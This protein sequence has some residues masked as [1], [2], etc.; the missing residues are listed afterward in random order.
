MPALVSILEAASPLLERF[1]GWI[2]K[3]ATSFANWIEGHRKSGKLQEFFDKVGVVFSKLSTTGKLVFQ[4]IGDILGILFNPSKDASDSVLDGV[5]GTLEKVHKWLGD[6]KNQKKVKDFFTSLKEFVQGLFTKENLQKVKDF[7]LDLRDFAKWVQEKG[8]PAIKKLKSTWETLIGPFVAVKEG[9]RLTSLVIS[10]ALGALRTTFY[11]KTNEIKANWKTFWDT[12]LGAKARTKAAEI[13]TQVGTWWGDLKNR[14]KTDSLAAGSTWNTWWTGLRG[15]ASSWQNT[16]RT[17]VGSWW[18][19]VRGAF[20]AG[21]NGGKSSW[22]GFWKSLRDRANSWKTAILNIVGSLKT[23]MIDRFKSLPND[24]L[25]TLRSVRDKIN[26]GI[27]KIN[28]ILPKQLDIPSIPKFADG[29]H[30]RG[31]GGEREDRIPALLSDNEYVLPAK[32]VRQIGVGNLDA[33]RAGRIGLGGDPGQARV[34]YADGGLVQRTQTFIRSTDPKPY[35][36][37]AVGPRGYDCSGLTGEVYN[38]LLGKASYQ[39]RFTTRSNFES[40]GFKRG[41]GA[42]TVGVNAAGGHMAGNLAGLPFEAASTKSGIKVGASAKSV[43][44]FPQQ[45]YLP[46]VGG[47]FVGSGSDFSAIGAIVGS[48]ASQI[49]S[50][51]AGLSSDGLA[52]LPK[53]VAQ[54]A[55][56]KV[57]QRIDQA[58]GFFGNAAGAVQSFVGGAVSKAQAVAWV[59]AAMAATGK[60]HP[61]WLTG[62]LTLTKRESNWNPNAINNWDSNARKGTPSKGIAQMIQ[63]TFDA[64][65]INGLGGIFNPIANIAASIRYIE[66]R[67]GDISRVQQANPNMPPKGYDNGGL[68]MPGYTLAYNGTGRAETIRT[69]SQEAALRTSTG[70]TVHIHLGAGAVQI[71]CDELDDMADVYRAI[72]KAPAASRRYASRT[73]AGVR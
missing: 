71:H 45:Y 27:G 18:T 40:I 3:V 19:S 10:T 56:D 33:L 25:G 16:I 52:R 44:S 42:Y 65:N 70:E 60:F 4:I 20:N 73:N 26:A 43:T 17:G 61:K 50:L 23:S 5:N 64:H 14:F 11:T 8:I 35:I 15:R 21:Q 22:E 6:E 48:I 67:Y 31:P 36:F 55:Q 37:G 54:L 29:G 51:V 57:K 13:K 66:S 53:G 63:P 34:A 68:L 38:R 12:G 46:Q 24:L 30:V 9:F 28:V 72:K 59:S 32:V 49:G 62:M 69:A 41:R 39:R 7:F 2:E 58:T 1:G 47:Q